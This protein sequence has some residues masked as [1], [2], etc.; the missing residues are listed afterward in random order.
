MIYGAG[1]REKLLANTLHVQAL[2]WLS[3]ADLARLHMAL[4]C[5]CRLAGLYRDGNGAVFAS[6]LSRYAGF[7]N[8]CASLGTEAKK[9]PYAITGIRLCDAR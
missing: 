8:A 6:L 4:V 1:S 2:Q 3:V 9:A 7:R 5:E